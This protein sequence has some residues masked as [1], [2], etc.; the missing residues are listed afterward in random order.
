MC[1]LRLVTICWYSRR[2]Q[3]VPHHCVYDDNGAK[4]Q[5]THYHYFNASSLWLTSFY[6][7][8]NISQCDE[9]RRRPLSTIKWCIRRKTKGH[10]DGRKK[11]KKRSTWIPENLPD[12]IIYVDILQI[13][14]IHIN[15][16]VCAAC[17]PRSQ[18]SLEWMD[19]IWPGVMQSVHL[20]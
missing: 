9:S 2:K 11:K 15:K 13:F 19:V 16:P 10:H 7:H 18:L 12:V 3:L 6:C 4:L 14:C 17:V 8:Y 20:V 1:S 5:P